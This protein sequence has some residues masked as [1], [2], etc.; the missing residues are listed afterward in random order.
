MKSE[1]KESFG[2]ESVSYEDLNSPDSLYPLDIRCNLQSGDQLLYSVDTLSSKE[3]GL[4]ENKSQIKIEQALNNHDR[5]LEANLDQPSYLSSTTTTTTF[6]AFENNQHGLGALDSIDMTQ[7]KGLGVS[8]EVVSP[9][10]LLPNVSEAP[11][12]LF[13][14][15]ELSDIGS[16]TASS[17]VTSPAPSSPLMDHSDGYFVPSPLKPIDEN[18][19]QSLQELMSLNEDSLASMSDIMELEQP[20]KSR[21]SSEDQ[22]PSSPV[23]SEDSGSVFDADGA[24]ASPKDFNFSEKAE[25]EASIVGNELDPTSIY[26]ACK[27]S[28][29]PGHTA[30]KNVM[31]PDNQSS[32]ESR[33]SC[34]PSLE[35]DMSDGKGM[36]SDFWDMLFSSLN[37]SSQ[38]MDVSP[39]A[40]PMKEPSLNAVYPTKESGMELKIVVQPESHHRA[41]YQTEGSRGCVKDESQNGFPTVKLTGYN[42]KYRLQVFVG[43]D[44]GKVKPHG[45]Y[46][47]SKVS[48]RNNTPSEEKTIDGTSVIEI[49]IDPSEDPLATVDCVGIMK[50][51]NADVEHKGVELPRSKKRSTR[52]RLVFRVN[53][54]KPDGTYRTLQVASTPISC[55]QPTGLPEISKKSLTSCSV[56]GGE[57]LFIL[58]KNFVRG[59]VVKFQQFSGEKVVWE[60]KAQIDRD[61]FQQSHLVCK[62]PAYKRKDV[63]EPVQVSI[64]ISTGNGRESDP[65]SF[66]YIPKAPVKVPAGD[67]TVKE[68]A[69]PT[70][71][72]ACRL[73]GTSSTTKAESISIIREQIASLEAVATQ[74]TQETSASQS[75]FAEQLKLVALLATG[76]TNKANNSN[77][78]AQRV[79]SVINHHKVQQKQQQQQA[80]LK[81]Q[82]SYIGVE[83]ENTASAEINEADNEAA[84]EQL[85]LQ[86]VPGVDYDLDAILDTLQQVASDVA[87]QS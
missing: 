59:T 1:C 82:Q 45:F 15:P 2:P 75:S 44:T 21:K 17:A 25:S 67:A 10:P 76:Q 41:R 79:L 63:T 33:S 52:A 38:E 3:L 64:V 14:F 74:T 58:G 40:A 80:L 32:H 73:S 27:S 37:R 60:E 65:Q 20:R 78:L 12:G 36:E 35:T 5:S 7:S 56:E 16:S 54:P 84:L 13:Q 22:S 34:W 83:T 9:F 24:V 66:T 53:L 71:A 47:A 43:N 18:S 68:K 85:I 77:V 87:Q 42:K 39:P 28:R 62:I 19:M 30:D 70:E 23:S 26:Q 69:E 11:I 8:N 57:E 72:S 55:T 86:G 49:Q 51:R 48:G 81:Q 29:T 6:P 46:Q 4:S 61:H 50:L 31:N